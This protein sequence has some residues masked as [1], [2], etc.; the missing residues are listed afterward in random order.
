MTLQPVYTEPVEIET[1]DN[2]THEVVNEQLLQNILFLRKNESTIAV[3][4]NTLTTDLS[5]P[6]TLFTG[7]IMLYMKMT[8]LGTSNFTDSNSEYTVFI[9][10]VSDSNNRIS[11]T[12]ISISGRAKKS[13]TIFRPFFNLSIGTH[14]FTAVLSRRGTAIKST[15]NE[16]AIWQ[17]P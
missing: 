17:I 2:L 14:I 8:A 12:S 10:D 1:G 3:W 11:S 16:F 9:D 4:D 5:F 15:L 6:L 7:H 13:S